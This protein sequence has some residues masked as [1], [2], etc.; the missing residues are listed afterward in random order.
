MAQLVPVF[1]GGGA[2]AGLSSVATIAAPIIGIAGGISRF[3]EGNAQA[4]EYE[5]QGKEERIMAGIQAAQLRREARQRQS[6][7]RV[8]MIEGGS[9]TGTGEGVLFQNAVAQEMDALAVEFQGEQRGRAADFQA[10]QSRGNI[11]DV[12]TS[13]INGFNQVDPLNIGN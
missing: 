2:M 7:D 5:R 8:A 9:F 3:A 4:A 11:L 13:A 10:R 1:L 6:R 12:F